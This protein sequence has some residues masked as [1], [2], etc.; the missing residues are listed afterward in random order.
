MI[1][2]R[3]RVRAHAP[4][5]RGPTWGHG[6]PHVLAPPPRRPTAVM[7]SQAGLALPA[8]VLKVLE[9]LPSMD[10]LKARVLHRC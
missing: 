4:A 7:A 6:E 9:K 3:R 8:Q 10:A 5:V 2:D 1:V